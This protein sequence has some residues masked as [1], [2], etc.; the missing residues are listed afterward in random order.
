MRYFR[1][2]LTFVG[3][4]I[5]IV[6][7]G[8]PLML[9]VMPFLIGATLYLAIKTLVV[10]GDAYDFGMLMGCLSVLGASLI[11]GLVSVAL[12]WTAINAMLDTFMSMMPTTVP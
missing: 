2:G 3:L 10:V 11:I 5:T 9:C 1:P 4:V 7:Q 8:S 12:S 6:S